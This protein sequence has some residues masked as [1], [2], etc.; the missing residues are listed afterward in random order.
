MCEMTKRQKT[1]RNS[2]GIFLQVNKKLQLKNNLYQV[3]INLLTSPLKLYLG[4]LHQTLQWFV[5]QDFYN[6]REIYLYKELW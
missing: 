4:R 5:N 6:E 3:K 2:F 1:C